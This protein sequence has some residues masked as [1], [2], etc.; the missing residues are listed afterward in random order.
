MTT[1]PGDALAI[2]LHGVGSSGRDL[3]PL[4]DA[5][6]ALLPRTHFSAPDA[7]NR[8]DQGSGRQWFSVAGVSDQNRSLRIAAARAD[9][10]RVLTAQL[11]E[12]GIS[13]RWERVALIGFSQG[14]IMA[15]DGMASGRWPIAAVVA[16]SGRLATPAPLSPAKGARAL[17]IHGEADPV[18]PAD[19][20]RRAAARLREVGVAVESH[21]L[22]GLGHTISPDGVAIAASFLA[23]SFGP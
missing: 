1:A 18:I 15:L 8:F 17:L 3:A 10:D 21:V 2:L 7:P 4:A 19:E 11:D 20:T 14:A 16:F 9:F 13:G 22:P 6:R 5:M 12:N 23:T